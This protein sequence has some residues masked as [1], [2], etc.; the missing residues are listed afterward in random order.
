KLVRADLPSPG[1]I[2]DVLAPV[3]ADKRIMFHSFTDAENDLFARVGADGR[4]PVPS[5][6]DLVSVRS[7]NGGNNKADLFLQRKIVYRPTFDPATGATEAKMTVTLTNEAPSSGLPEAFLGS[8]DRGLP[9]GTNR[10]Y[11]SVYSPLGLRKASIDGQEHGFE[12]QK[13]LGWSVYSQFLTIPPG[14]T[15]TVELDLFGTLSP[16]TYRLQ[17]EAQPMVNPDQLL[18]ELE[19]TSGWAVASA[20]ASPKGGFAPESG[21]SRAVLA[22]PLTGDVDLRATFRER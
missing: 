21:G 10:M 19:P 12:F 9:P 14:G 3:V 13:E 18:V 2:A 15:V 11:F 16:T 5:G 1:R 22:A 20:T 8:N 6:G 7:Q 4:F 17:V